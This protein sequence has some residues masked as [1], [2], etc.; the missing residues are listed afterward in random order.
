MNGTGRKRIVVSDTDQQRMDEV[1][2]GRW[3]VSDLIEAEMD[4]TSVAASVGSGTD[5]AV[6]MVRPVTP[7]KDEKL[8]KIFQEFEDYLKRTSKSP[9]TSEAHQFSEL[10]ALPEFVESKL[11][12]WIRRKR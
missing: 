3:S 8:E 7:F 9:T 2:H 5:R 10:R 4:E 1:I 12:A 6:G 11:I